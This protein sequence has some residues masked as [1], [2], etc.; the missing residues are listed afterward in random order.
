M[1][2]FSKLGIGTTFL[3]VVLFASVLLVATAAGQPE[4]DPHRPRCTDARCRQTKSFLKA[5]YCGE[6]PFGNGPDD[7]CEIKSPKKPQSEFEVIADF[8]C[9]WHEIKQCRQYEQPPPA[10]RSVVLSEL[11]RLG[12]PTAEDKNAYFIVFKSTSSGWSVA[13]GSYSRSVG[14]ELRLCEVI[15]VIGADSHVTVLRKVRFQKTDADV[16]TITTWSLLGIADVDG[17]KKPDIILEGEA[18]EDHWLEVD[19]VRCSSWKTIFSGL[20]YYL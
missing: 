6:S 12:L 9:E 13:Q 18:Y 11:H 1:G 15:L 17:D 4:K 5:H 14:S 16:P 3:S 2:R 10:V 20:G 8:R 19:S 7:G